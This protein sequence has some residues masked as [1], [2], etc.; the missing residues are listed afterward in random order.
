MKDKILDYLN[1]E[2]SQTERVDF[3]NALAKDPI[4]QQ[5]FEFY[6]NKWIQLKTAHLQK[7]AQAKTKIWT[8]GAEKLRR[9][10][11]ILRLTIAMTA[12]TTCVGVKF[13]YDKW[14]NKHKMNIIEPLRRTPENQVRIDSIE[15]QKP[16]DKFQADVPATKAIKIEP[17]KGL[18]GDISKKTSVSPA[19]QPST[20]HHFP[21][22]IQKSVE[23]PKENDNVPI[24]ESGAGINTIKV[25][26]TKHYQMHSFDSVLRIP[27]KSFI[28]EDLFVQRI[29]LSIHSKN[30]ESI[31]K[32]IHF[33]YAANQQSEQIELEDTDK[34]E[35]TTIAVFWFLKALYKFENSEN[36][37][38]GVFNCLDRIPKG[39]FETE[40]LFYRNIFEK[41]D[42]ITLQSLI[43]SI[44]KEPQNLHYEKAIELSKYIKH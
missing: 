15:S 40:K 13:A 2:L 20:V 31:K 26:E 44:A 35:E 34:I 21:T 37:L 14:Q 3:E 5:E 17:S 28:L 23:I 32:L 25:I 1:G 8:A 27:I 6:K 11:R 10:Q 4:L 39:Y 33:Y 19:K 29:E 12:V 18:I 41:K 22:P 9:Q 43:E 7:I 16:V 24:T 30:N 36:N 42:N 38:R